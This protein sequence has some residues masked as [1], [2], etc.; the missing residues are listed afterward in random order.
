MST[1][2]VL[3]II[4]L[5]LVIT[6]LVVGG[7]WG[8]RQRRSAKLRERFGPEFTREVRVRG[9][10]R[11]AEQHLS[12]V[13]HRRDRLDIRPLEPKARQQYTARWE[14]VQAEFVDQPGPALDKA[15][16][17][18]TEVMRERGYPTEEFTA[19]AQLVAADHP[20]VVEHYRAARAVRHAPHGSSGATS[21][22]DLRQ[23]FVHYRA[24]FN[25]L[26]TDG[27]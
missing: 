11:E 22:E 17:L 24:L 2:L 1:V 5:V 27:R 18:V 9:S 13:A 6:G 15:D 23:A 10:E 3:V 25:E 16:Q 21:T 19:Q 12:E 14:A 26:V 7:V 20:H 8:A 4:I